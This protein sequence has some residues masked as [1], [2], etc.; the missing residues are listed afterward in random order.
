VVQVHQ[1]IQ[2]G[3]D[4]QVLVQE[5]LELLAKEQQAEEITQVHLILQV[6]AVVPAQQAETEVLVDH[7][8]VAVQDQ[9]QVF[10]VLR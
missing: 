8:V 5:L 2:L 10:P 3:Q 1:V 6:A 9:H 7:Q 4:Q